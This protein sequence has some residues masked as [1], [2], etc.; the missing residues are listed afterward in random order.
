[1]TELRAVRSMEALQQMG[2]VRTTVRRDSAAQQVPADEIVPGD[3]VLLEGGDMITA[4]LRLL[5][6]S[7]LEVDE[8]AL[9]GESVPVGKQ[10]GPVGVDT[11]LAE[12]SNMAFKG[13]GV[14][15][16][17]AVGIAVATGIRTEL[18]RISSLVESAEAG[19]TPLEDRLDHLARTLLWVTLAIVTLVGATG[20][21]RGREIVFMVETAIALAVAAIPEGLPIVATIA[22]ARGMQRMARRNALISRL[23]AVET[24]GGTTVICT[25]KTGTLT[26]NRMTVTRY[27]L[28]TGAVEVPSGAAD[29]NDFGLDGDAP[30]SASPILCTA[31]E[32]GVLCSNASLGDD[33]GSDAV[34]DPLEVALLV[35]GRKAGIHRPELLKDLPEVREVAFDPDAR[36]MATVHETA[37]GYRFAVKG[38]PEAVLEH[39]TRI[40]HSDG[41]HPLDDEQREQWSGRNKAMA[42]VGLR[43]LALAEKTADDADDDA[44]GDLTFLGL[45]GLKDP[46]RSDAHDA[47]VACQDAGIRVVMVTG[48]QAMTAWS[49][50]RAVG[51]VDE[52]DMDVVH[53]RELTSL[54][55][56]TDEEREHI[57]GALVLARVSP[58][59]KLDLI[60]LY[61][62]AG[63]IVAMTGDG[64][65]DAPALKKADIGVA[66]GRRGTQVAREAADMVLTD[67]SFSTIVA[68]VE[69]GR[70]IFANIRRFVVYLFSCNLSEILVVGL[71]SV[72]SA[73]LPILPLQILFLNLV[74][75][76]FPALALG[77][78]SAG[79]GVMTEAPRDPEESIV[80]RHHWL[81]IG[82]YGLMITVAVLAGLALALRWFGFDES[83]A[84]TVSFLTLAFAQL[85]HVFTMRDHD[86]KLIR[87]AI[88]ANPYVWGALA[89]STALLVLA[90]YAPGLSTVLGV[91]D[92]GFTGWMLVLGL[93][94]VPAIA[95]QV[96]KVAGFPRI[97]AAPP[98]H[99]A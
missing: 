76:V 49:V 81:A 9:T 92:P 52:H 22:L 54:D 44:F 62:E 46:P 88:T 84:V 82:A 98:R 77:T 36:L 95:G 3:V 20:I 2:S 50:A 12:R 26:E 24:L 94:I 40:G 19:R 48:D 99:R 64:V 4:D 14:T 93:S 45:V 31:L 57:L 73:P 38:G 61:Q 91:E 13:T 74:T 70:A 41:N 42:E 97:Q 35:A 86:S 63:E 37:E 79:R 89:L 30:D 29:S 28:E 15:R 90:V 1:V 56:A 18:G 16:G 71:A 96:L 23:S 78:I 17:S 47:V 85:W 33:D 8:S 72:A 58:K 87:N 68:A 11:P 34:G 43:V 32:V 66:M 75:D 21:L 51:L 67:D 80:T 60:A 10:T 65:N 5:E 53:G 83:R 69:E 6:T 7:L 39:C 25:D 55:E 27:E 59:Q